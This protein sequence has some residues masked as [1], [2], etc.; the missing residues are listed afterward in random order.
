MLDFY[1][2][3]DVFFSLRPELLNKVMADVRLGV[4]VLLP[5]IESALPGFDPRRFAAQIFLIGHRPIA[6][7]N[8]AGTS[9]IRNARLRADPGACKY[10]DSIAAADIFGKIT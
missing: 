6:R 4:F 3:I 1:N 7:P 8:S 9:E 2:N 5:A 10:N